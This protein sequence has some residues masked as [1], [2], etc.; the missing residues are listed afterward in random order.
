MCK[1]LILFKKKIKYKKTLD[2]EIFFKMTHWKT[3]YD[4]PVPSYL[5]KRRKIQKTPF[6]ENNVVKVNFLDFRANIFSLL[7]KPKDGKFASWKFCTR[8]F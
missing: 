5:F 8:L 6:V 4:V 7:F 1:K 2:L 3:H